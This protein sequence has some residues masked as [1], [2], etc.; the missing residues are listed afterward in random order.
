MDGRDWSWANLSGDKL[1]MLRDAE[2]TLGVDILLAYKDRAG[3]AVES[4]RLGQTGLQVASMND[5]QVECLQGLE[6]K[7]GAVVIGYSQAA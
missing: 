2:Q 3:S 5:S 4:R 6:Q 7:L 1:D